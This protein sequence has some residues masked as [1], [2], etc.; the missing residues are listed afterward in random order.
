MYLLEVQVY[1]PKAGSSMSNPIAIMFLPFIKESRK[2]KF[3]CIYLN[4]QDA[5][6]IAEQLERIKADIVVNC[7]GLT[8]V[9][10]CEENPVQATQTNVEITKRIGGICTN[11]H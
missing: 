3:K 2:S 7:I 4:Y 8:S 9:E 5:A 10:E 11:G 6:N 1:W